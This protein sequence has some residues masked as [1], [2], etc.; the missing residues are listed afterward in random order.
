MK[1]ARVFPTKTSMCPTDKHA[2]FNEPDLFTPNYDEIHISVTF[3]WDIAKAYKLVNSWKS[4]GKVKIGGMA[5]NG[6]SDKPVS[7]LYLKEGV[8]ITSRGCPNGCSFCLVK[9]NLLN[10]MSSQ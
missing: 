1:I 10:L 3:T 8:T 6:E 7:G 4:K 2:Y 5:I 9:K